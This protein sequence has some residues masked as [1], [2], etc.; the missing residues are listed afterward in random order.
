M[1]TRAWWYT[2]IIQILEVEVER[3]KDEGH[4]QLQNK[5][6]ESWDHE[7]AKKHYSV[8]KQFKD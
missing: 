8:Q 2:T 1:S 7:T 4:T 5:A 3:L 6:E